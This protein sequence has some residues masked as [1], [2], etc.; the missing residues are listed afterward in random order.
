MFSLFLVSS[1][2]NKLLLSP[3]SSAA[4]AKEAREGDFRSA[5]A[6]LK[7]ESEA[8]A[9]VQGAKEA[10]RRAEY[11]ATNHLKANLFINSVFVQLH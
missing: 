11:I 7:A 9:F 10:R 6:Q 5:H 1:V 4:A 2:I 3:V 8:V